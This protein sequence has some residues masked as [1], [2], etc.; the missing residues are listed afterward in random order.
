MRLALNGATIMHSPLADDLEIAAEAGF[1]ALEVWAGKLDV[2]LRERSLEELGGRMQ[3]LGVQPWCIN[4]IED[5]TPRDALGRAEIIEQLGRTV[6]IARAIGAPSIVV[7]PGRAPDGLGRAAA[8]ADAVNVLRMM[9]DVSGDVGLA[10]EFLGKPGCAVPTLDMAIEIVEAVDR[11]NV[12]MVI[13]TFHFYAG[14][15]EMADLVRVPVDKL[16]AVHLNGCEDRP[17][18]ELTDAHRLFPG[19]GVIPIEAILRALRARGFDGTMSVEIFRPEYW[20][21]EPRDV[22][23][24]ARAKAEGVLT[25]AGYTING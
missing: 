17:K 18:G 4:S 20:K 24:E 11:P 25:K 5:I 15:S 8:I 22:A 12:G 10:F 16:F 1:T 6:A 3:A 14:G 9:S 13:D 19:E 7:V 21:R 23:R 2:Y